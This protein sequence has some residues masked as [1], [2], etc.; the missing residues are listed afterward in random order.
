[1]L[2]EPSR[3]AVRINRTPERVAEDEIAVGV[4]IGGEGAL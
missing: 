2:A 1:M 4:G 3:D